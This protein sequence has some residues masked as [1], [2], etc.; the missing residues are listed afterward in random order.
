MEASKA[1]EWMEKHLTTITS[2]TRPGSTERE[3]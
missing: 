3:Y 1:M 2:T